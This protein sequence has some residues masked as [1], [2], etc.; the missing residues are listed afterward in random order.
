VYLADFPVVPAE[1]ITIHKSQ[2]ATYREVMVHT[3]KDMQR[4]APYV[5]CSRG[6]SAAGLYI[7]GPFVPPKSASQ[8]ELST[9][10]RKGCTATLVM[11]VC[12]DQL[13]L[14]HMIFLARSLFKYRYPTYPL[15][16]MILR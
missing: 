10:V 8:E 7:I 4:A 11:Y 6:T 9:I 15:I 5:A 3:R 13:M 14:M 16:L 12:S 1:A 2:E